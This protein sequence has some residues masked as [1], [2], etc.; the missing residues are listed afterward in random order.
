MKNTHQK[1]IVSNNGKVEAIL[2]EYKWS[3]TK[4][5]TQRMGLRVLNKIKWKG[6]ELKSIN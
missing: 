4:Q 5:Q 1:N 2:E 3:K 6:I